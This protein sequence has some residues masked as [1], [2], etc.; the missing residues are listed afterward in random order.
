MSTNAKN[1]SYS[2]PQL[3]SLISI[4]EGRFFLYGVSLFDLFEDIKNAYGREAAQTI[5][6]FFIKQNLANK[7]FMEAFNKTSFKL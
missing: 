4:L 5:F 7:K 2:S 3:L 1:P 6:Y